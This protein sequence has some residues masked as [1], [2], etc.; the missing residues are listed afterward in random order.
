[1]WQWYCTFSHWNNKLMPNVYFV[2]ISI[3]ILWLV[4]GE[5]TATHVFC[6]HILQTNKW[7]HTWYITLWNQFLSP[8]LVSLPVKLSAI[9]IRHNIKII[10]LPEAVH[11]PSKSFSLARSRAR[12]NWK[13]NIARPTNPNRWRPSSHHKNN[14]RLA[15]CEA[16]IYIL[17][18]GAW[19][20]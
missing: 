6:H 17:M 2:S 20:R 13:E 19:W 11:Q 1:M 15:I 7:T 18:V 14:W 10:Y 8:A 3:G 16:I 4:C 9:R 12:A 5:A